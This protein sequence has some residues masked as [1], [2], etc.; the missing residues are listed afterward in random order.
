MAESCRTYSSDSREGIDSM[1]TLGQIQHP[2]A[3]VSLFSWNGKFIVKIEQGF[4]EQVYKFDHLDFDDE[5]EFRGKIDEAFVA[6]AV[7]RFSEM[8]DVHSRISR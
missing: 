7:S 1:R 6:A 5:T 8:R 2:G 3:V 4:L